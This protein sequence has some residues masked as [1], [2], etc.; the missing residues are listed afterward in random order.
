MFRERFR[1]HTSVTWDS[2]DFRPC[3]RRTW[4]PQSVQGTLIPL[5][6]LPAGLGPRAGEGSGSTAF[7]PAEGAGTALRWR[8][9]SFADQWVLAGLLRAAPKPSRV[10]E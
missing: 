1:V 2:C 7:P 8:R 9:G 3:Y 6:N 5:W 4:L 10:S